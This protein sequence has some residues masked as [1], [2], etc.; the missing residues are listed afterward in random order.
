MIPDPNGPCDWCGR[1]SIGTMG[2][3]RACPSHL[4][5]LLAG[6]EPDQ[7]AELNAMTP[8]MRVSGHPVVG[9]VWERDA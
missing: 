4:S 6:L 7:A 1:I 8:T 5:D 3:W 2:K 9:I